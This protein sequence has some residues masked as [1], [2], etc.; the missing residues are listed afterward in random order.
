V[1]G[2][3]VAG[4]GH[5]SLNAHQQQLR[6]EWQADRG[7]WQAVG[8]WRSFVAASGQRQQFQ[9]GEAVA[10]GDSRGMGL[11]LGG[12]YRLSEQWRL[13]LALGLQEQR[14]EAGEADSE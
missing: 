1:A 13:G 2:V 3:A 11:N 5:G 6:S 4:N 10:D 7:A 14:L 8:Q 12:S 9:E